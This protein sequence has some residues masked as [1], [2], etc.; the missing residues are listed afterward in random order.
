MA[1][2]AASAC[3]LAEAGDDPLASGGNMTTESFDLGSAGAI[4]PREL[5]LG[6]DG[7][8]QVK[9]PWAGPYHIVDNHCHNA[10]AANA[11]KTDGYIGCVAES[12]STSTQGHTINWAPDPSAGGAKGSYC[13]Y[14]PQA[15]GGTASSGGVCCWS[16]GG[17]GGRGEPLFDTTGAQDC[18]KKLC[19]GQADF[20][21]WFRSWWV[22]PPKAYPAGS[23]P[24]V[25][26]DCP[27]STSSSAACNT[28][29]TK[30]A[31]EV[32][33]LF[34]DSKE[35]YRQQVDEYEKRCATG[36]TDRDLVR[37]QEAAKKAQQARA[38]ADAKACLSSA[39][40]A[41]QTGTQAKET[42]KDDT[43]KK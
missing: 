27:G 34:G 6:A 18:V 32:M 21:G 41:K 43:K 38:K 26:N 2:L 42:C 7:K 33:D 17:V 35:Q 31:D 5:V 14:E 8:P 36:C 15:N 25:A 30:Q 9:S 13:A 24:L 37:Q 20:P 11:S 39:L 3:A 19:L 1:A 12:A 23:K 28:C 29:C 10:A 22:T 16:G 4:R 40:A